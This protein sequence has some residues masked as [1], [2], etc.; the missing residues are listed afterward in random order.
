M[1]DYL[2]VALQDATARHLNSDLVG[3]ID[4]GAAQRI[5]QLGMGHDTGAAPVELDIDAL[6]NLN[7]PADTVQQQ[8]RK[9]PGHGPADDQGP[10]FGPL[11]SIH[12][13]RSTFFRIT[14]IPRPFAAQKSAAKS[15][16]IGPAR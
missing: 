15:P 8:R 13:E 5:D 4:T 12:S 6:E 7:V 14:N 2:A 9:Q 11:A 10:A 1:P 3:A 16:L